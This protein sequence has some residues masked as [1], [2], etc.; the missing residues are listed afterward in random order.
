M[1]SRPRRCQDIVQRV[2]LACVTVSFLLSTSSLLMF[3][4]CR[5]CEAHAETGQN[6][7]L[8]RLGRLFGFGGHRREDGTMMK[9]GGK[10]QEATH[11]G[12]A[13]RESVASESVRWLR[14]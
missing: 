12:S 5:L 14:R 9:G 2:R 10:I 4:T 8:L 6:T 11:R 1:A 13:G 7:G 3:H